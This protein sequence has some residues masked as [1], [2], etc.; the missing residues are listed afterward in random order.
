MQAPTAQAFAANANGILLKVGSNSDILSL[1]SPQHQVIDLHGQHVVPVSIFC[2]CL[3]ESF[4][5]TT[6]AHLA[7][8]GLT[9]TGPAF[10][11]I[12]TVTNVFPPLCLHI[13]QSKLWLH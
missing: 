6:V 3:Y 12:G 8:L 1:A 2:S 5:N 9:G 11:T 10:P 13:P 7:E 4:H